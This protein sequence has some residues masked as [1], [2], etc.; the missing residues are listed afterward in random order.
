MDKVHYHCK[1]CNYK[2]KRTKDAKVKAC[3]Y[4]GSSQIVVYKPTLAEDLL[5]SVE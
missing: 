2:F 1:S 3:P 4:C 5:N